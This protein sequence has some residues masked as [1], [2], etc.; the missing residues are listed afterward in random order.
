MGTKAGIGVG[1]A[2]G[3]IALI[4]LG[5]FIG[6][7]SHKKK[8]EATEATTYY[9]PVRAEFPSETYRHEASNQDGSIYE[10]PVTQKHAE[11][12]GVPIEPQELPGPER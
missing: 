8:K 12:H 3:V 1:A 10:A 7:R 11:L 5:A 9:E 6:R 2:F 4:A